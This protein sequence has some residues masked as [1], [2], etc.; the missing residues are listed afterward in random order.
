MKRLSEAVRMFQEAC[1]RHDQL[2]DAFRNPLNA[3]QEFLDAR[4]AFIACQPAYEAARQELLEVLRGM[5]NRGR[6]I[7]DYDRFPAELR[8]VVLRAL[9]EE[10][11]E[12]LLDARRKTRSF[13]E[14]VQSW[15]L[16]KV[17][18]DVAAALRDARFRFD[19]QEFDQILTRVA[20]ERGE[21]GELVLANYEDTL[22]SRRDDGANSWDAVRIVNDEA[23]RHFED[24]C[25]QIIDMVDRL[26]SS[27]DWE[28]EKHNLDLDVWRALCSYIEIHTPKLQPAAQAARRT[29][30][31]VDVETLDHAAN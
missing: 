15:Y 10:G 21:A 9:R 17:V 24:L 28:E 16:A 14:L 22:E 6:L 11:L 3:L 20:E 5:H 18:A 13:G 23:R 8:I 2:K 19:D 4:E 25:D 27:G 29:D 26:R 30:A 31:V 12:E 7:S 1:V